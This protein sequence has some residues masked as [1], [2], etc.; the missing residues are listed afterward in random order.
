M[1]RWV[2]LLVLLAAAGCKRSS[3]SIDL[4][5]P[6]SDDTVVGQLTATWVDTGRERTSDTQGSRQHQV[7]VRIDARNRLSDPLYIR[8]RNLRLIATGGPVA[9]P[10]ATAA[11]TLAPGI[12]TGVVKG[13]V[14][15]PAS[16]ADSVRSF[17]IDHVAVPLSERG[18]AFYREF[19]LRQRPNDAAAIDAELAAFA[20]APACVTAEDR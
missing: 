13:R 16:E 11:C 10:E 1:G 19:L 20:A 6:F 14:W 9:A 4:M 5:P 17:E 15:L 3:G 7:S 2:A 18:R 12:T 8:L